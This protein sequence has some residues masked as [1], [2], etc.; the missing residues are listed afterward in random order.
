MF[1]VYVIFLAAS[2]HAWAEVC[3]HTAAE[4]CHRQPQIYG[5]LTQATLTVLAEES[6]AQA[7]FQTLSQ[8]FCGWMRKPALPVQRPEVPTD[9]GIQKAWIILHSIIQIYSH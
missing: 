5:Q 3:H 4:V 2:A 1:I 8:P 6:L 9:P 7:S